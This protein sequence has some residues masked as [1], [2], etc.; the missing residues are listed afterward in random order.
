[1]R[2]AT[3]LHMFTPMPNLS[4]FDVNMAIDAGWQYCIPYTGLETD[5]IPDFTQDVIFSRGPKGAAMTGIF[6]GGRDIFL[7]LDMLE[8]AKQSMVPPFEVSVFADPS[9]AF[10][11]AAGMIACTERQLTAQANGSLEGKKVFVFGG[12]GPVGATCGMLAAQSGADVGL[13]SHGS[14]ARAEGVVAKCAERYGVQMQGHLAGNDD[15][16]KELLSMADVVFGAAKAGVQILN[17]THLAAATRLKVACDVNVVP[18][19]GIAGVGVMDDGKPIAATPGGAV[20]IGALAVG[21]IKYRTQSAL[22]Q[23]M[24]ETEA[25]VY[26]A[27]EKALAEARKQ[28]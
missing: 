13:V 4:P 5:Q 16:T 8:S 25:P 24:V 19:E 10:T 21:N 3:I 20:G 28:V 12:T 26:L 11:T 15:Q 9:G 1:M 23:H 22:L 2:R 27:Y 18:P 14:K 6:I 17:D 7:A